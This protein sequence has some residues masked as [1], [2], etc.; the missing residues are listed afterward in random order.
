[1][2]AAS[3]ANS[4]KHGF[5][6]SF[7]VLEASNS[8]APRDAE[9]PVRV[10][11]AQQ[12]KPLGSYKPR[13]YSYRH[14]VFERAVRNLERSEITSPELMELEQQ[15]PHLFQDQPTKFDWPQAATAEPLVPI[16]AI[17]INDY[18]RQSHPESLFRTYSKDVSWQ[19]ATERE[20]RMGTLRALTGEFYTRYG[21]FAFASVHTPHFVTNKDPELSSM[22]AE[23]YADY[24][25]MEIHG[26]DQWSANFEPDHMLCLY[27]FCLRR[28]DGA[29][30]L[31]EVPD[32]TMEA[33]FLA[34]L[35]VKGLLTEAQLHHHGAMLGANHHK[36]L[37]Y[38]KEM[39]LEGVE[40]DPA[41]LALAAATPSHNRNTR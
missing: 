8:N 37:R 12:S 31:H 13:Y 16:V 3:M 19:L 41:L 33:R 14:I 17:C 25:Y 24:H 38:I 9:W 6:H 36:I 30:T 40:P 39:P 7:K 1:M 22:L 27:P 21:G 10:L 32:P 20:A 29:P 35:V 4:I 23:R 5:Y 15:Q 26:V 34:F 28:A 11:E 2:G 18:V